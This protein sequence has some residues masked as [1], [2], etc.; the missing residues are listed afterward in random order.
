MNA[1]FFVDTNVLVYAYDR[2]EPE[3]Q[4]AALD[5]LDRLAVRGQ[6]VLST[7]VLSEMFVTITRKVAAPLT[8]DEALKRLENYYRSWPVLEVTGL[9]VLE[10]AR[11][12]RDHQLNYWDSLIWSCAKLNQIEMV[13]S[14]DFNTGSVIEGVQFE[15]PFAEGF[16]L[17]DSSS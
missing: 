5:V 4:R 17:L 14:E 10:A 3:K 15:N 8:V 2:A 13:L 1:S 12:V 16:A 11:G 6:G 7:Q 9:I